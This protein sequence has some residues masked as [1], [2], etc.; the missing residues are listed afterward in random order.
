MY[1]IN[2]HALK[3]VAIAPTEKSALAKKLQKLYL[4][5][6]MVFIIIPAFSQQEQ[7]GSNEAIIEKFIE[8]IASNTDRELDYTT[9][10]EDLT[11]YLNEPLNINEATKP[12]LEKLQLLSDFQVNA[13]LQYQKDY[14]QFLSIYELLNVSGFNEEYLR[15]ILPFITVKKIVPI[16][17]FSP[18]KAL[19]YGSNKIFMRTQKV[20]EP[21]IG[22]SP[23]TD[24]ALAASP[25]SRYLGSPYKMLFRY[26]FT[27][28]T[29]I[30][31]G[32]TADK[33]PGEEFF[34]GSQKRGFDFYSAHLLLKDIGPV[35]TIVLG[36][37][38]A[39]FG[40]GLV[41]FSGYNY[42]KSSMVTSTR[43]KAQGLKKFSGTDENLFYRGAGATFR[44]AKID[45]TAFASKKKI[46][47]NIT[48]IDSLTGEAE[49]ISSLQTSG[50][51]AYPSELVDRKSVSETV[52]G[53]NISLNMEKFRLGLTGIQ[54]SYGAN[55][56]KTPTVYN[57]YDFSG[58][59]NTNIGA[60]YQLMLKDVT[61]FGE[62]ALSQ[63]G[64]K[65]FISG[66]LF[67]L[68]SQINMALIYRNYERDYQANFSSAFGENSVNANEH[69][70]YIGTT[71]YP[72][73]KWRIA[74]YYDLFTFPWL[75]SGV[76]APSKGSDYLVEVGYSPNR[77]IS[78]YIRY[79]QKIKQENIPSTIP[80][81]IDGIENNTTTK[82]RFHISYKVSRTISLQ[83]RL[84]WITY[85]KEPN[86]EKGFLIYQDFIYKPIKLPLT[87]SARYCIF[88]T[89]GYDSRLYE[90]ESDVLYAFS[91]P[92]YYN[93]G[94]RFY[95]NI[96][97]SVNKKIDLW[98]RYGQTYYSN[99]NTISSG[100]TQIDGKTKT[101]VKLQIRI[102]L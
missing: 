30:S 52:L 38:Y 1:F 57:Q 85:Q 95:F 64:G 88:D 101:E 59:A 34:K 24:S 4:I 44:F 73:A 61:I 17:G 55:L 29:K 7:A 6:A 78:S 82:I 80:S 27:Y 42:G 32:I 31:W 86:N 35:K 18:Q 74:G 96:K 12:D 54:Y 75:K 3:V 11:F 83:N 68:S 22:Y 28:K 79:R 15:M 92:A 26:S 91:I 23:I 43:K 53:G 47:A 56:L 20:L 9:L 41:V 14:G 71:I 62:G 63:N 99:L 100:L 58:R 81:V 46:D 70:F 21:Q 33:D 67:N 97:Y 36:D 50:E 16:L 102:L 84:D 69:G 65:A 94:T 98:F 25:N 51:H 19:K 45:F 77:Q 66:M 48:A 37:Y 40:Q 89:D 76:Y 8:D 90:Y 13:I 2:Y 49:D 60:N 39:Q 72:Y 93:K 5:I 10:Y 87:F